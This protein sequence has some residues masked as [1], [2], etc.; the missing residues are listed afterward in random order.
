MLPGLAK[1]SQ[2]SPWHFGQTFGATTTSS[3]SKPQ[4]RHWSWK[5]STRFGA[6]RNASYVAKRPSDAKRSM[7]IDMQNSFSP[8][9]THFHPDRVNRVQR[10]CHDAEKHHF[11]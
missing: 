4:Q 1:R 3:G 7:L 2:A 6:E 10:P 8:R 9:V 11:C 5:I